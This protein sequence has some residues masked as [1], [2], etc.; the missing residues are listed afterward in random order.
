MTTSDGSGR[1]TTREA[2]V[3]EYR[4]GSRIRDT[5]AGTWFPA[6]SPDDSAAGLLLVHPG[7][8]LRVLLPTLKRLAELSLPGVLPMNPD[9]TTQSGRNWITATAPPGPALSDVIDEGPHR[10]PG[11]AALVLRDIGQTLTEVHQAGL[12]HG[13]LA[14]TSVVLAPNG[15]AVLTDWAT[16]PGAN[17]S[18]DVAAWTQLAR[19]LAERWCV[20]SPEGAAALARAVGAAASNGLRAGCEQLTGLAEAGQR[21]L[22]TNAASIGPVPARR[23][24]AARKKLATLAATPP[25][26]APSLKPP[27]P[28]PAADRRAPETRQDAP[29]PET[30]RSEARDAPPPT[31]APPA[32]VPPTAAPPTA[33]PPAAAAASAAL[34]ASGAGTATARSTDSLASGP[35]ESPPNSNGAA[36]AGLAAQASSAAAPPDSSTEHAAG[37]S[38]EPEAPPTQ[39]PDRQPTVEQPPAPA[40]QSAPAPSQANPFRPPPPARRDTP[41]TAWERPPQPTPVSPTEQPTQP[42]QRPHQIAG[43]PPNTRR[44]SWLADPIDASHLA[45]VPVPPVTPKP[46]PPTQQATEAGSRESSALQMVLIGV[47]AVI[48]AAA[49]A[50]LYLRINR[51]DDSGNLQVQS[52]TLQASPHDGVCM[53]TATINT[54]GRPGQL[55]Y[56]W[57]GELSGEPVLTVSVPDDEHHVTLG[58][59]WSGAGTTNP[60]PRVSIQILNPT[61]QSSET[62]PASACP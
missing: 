58:R 2:R 37:P 19:L 54:N 10:L 56:R 35:P 15:H 26:D 41:P 24:G 11:N 52:V 34:A 55:T 50:L 27:A 61:P 21:E 51:T 30:A 4:R 14:T 57:S 13:R 22:L 18:D 42:T 31:A 9:L 59:S 39:G 28:S 7:V 47:L 40:P 36:P 29:S 38:F 1:R 46:K 6:V 60:D 23:R 48:L 32:A 25:A 12:A 16:N 8:D 5:P 49:S 44:P 43:P 53:L 45:T 33:V 3:G 62:R 17:Q 20:E